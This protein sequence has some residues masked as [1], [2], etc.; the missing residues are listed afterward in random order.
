VSAIKALSFV[1]V[2]RRCSTFHVLCVFLLVLSFPVASHADCTDISTCT[3][4][5]TV[6][7]NSFELHAAEVL[8]AITASRLAALQQLQSGIATAQHAAYVQSKADQARAL[9]QRARTLC[10]ANKDGV[11]TRSPGRA[12][13][14]LLQAEEAI[15]P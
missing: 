11:C 7:I 10:A 14:L 3:V 15:A 13:A 8:H 2:S 12:A 9:Y 4:D 1:N 5:S 6:A